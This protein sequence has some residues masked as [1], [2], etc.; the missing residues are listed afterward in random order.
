[1]SS[2][3]AEVRSTSNRDP[4]PG[5]GR[6]ERRAALGAWLALV[7]VPA[8]GTPGCAQTGEDRW[9]EA[10]MRLVAEE[11][12][13]QGIDDSATLAA[14]RAVPRHEF[15]PLEQRPYAYDNTPLPIGHGQTISQPL[16]VAM[17][18]QL[19]G[20][21]PGLRVLEV[22]TGSGYQAAVLAETGARVWTIEI[23]GRLADAARQRLARLGYGA[24]AV[25]HGDGY[26]G[27]AA[28]APFDAIVVT[29]GADSI[30]PP[31][32]EQLGPGGRLV[33]PIGDPATGQDLVLVEKDS[34]GGMASR[35]VLPVRFVPLLRGVR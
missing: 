5:P 22:G 17:M 15:V 4:A 27:W 29:A 1:M 23:F 2:G 13:H 14:M 34:G 8:A 11:L 12:T 18:T 19:V 16:V 30:P 33:M 35:R 32:L 20:P 31:L 10:R 7:L 21:R 9:Q 24:V 25:R 26:A 3:S 6:R 28:E